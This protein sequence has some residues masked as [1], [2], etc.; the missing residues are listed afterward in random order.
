M[1]FGNPG[2]QAMKLLMR[3][4]QVNVTFKKAPKAQGRKGEQGELGL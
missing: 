2:I 1:E 4:G 3:N